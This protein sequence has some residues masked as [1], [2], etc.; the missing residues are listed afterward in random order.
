MNDGSFQWPIDPKEIRI[1]LVDDDPMIRELLK[2][3]LR[4]LQHTHILE[5]ESGEE[6]IAL[7]KESWPDL[8]FLDIDMPGELNGMAVL[9]E[10][11]A[12]GKPVYITMIT[13]YGTLDNVRQAAA[14]KIDGFLLKPV[15]T[16]R[17][18]RALEDFHHAER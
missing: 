2:T 4:K 1:L 5:S 14:K 10:V 12:I 3:T 8:I 17:I 18:R 11:R 16:D 7:C 9:H 13:A 6:A 15:S